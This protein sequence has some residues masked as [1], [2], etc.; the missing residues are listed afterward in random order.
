MG[1]VGNGGV[2]TVGSATC[3]AGGVRELEMDFDGDHGGEA[4]VVFLWPG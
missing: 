4:W 2:V 1:A 3:G